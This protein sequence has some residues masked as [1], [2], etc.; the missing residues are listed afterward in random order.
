[1]CVTQMLDGGI[2]SKLRYTSSENYKTS[3]INNEI[4][5]SNPIYLNPVVYI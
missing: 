1:M 2:L 3:T 4:D 5:I